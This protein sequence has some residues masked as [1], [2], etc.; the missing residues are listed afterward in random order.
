MEASNACGFVANKTSLLINRRERRER[1]EV[2]L[3][4]F[5]VFSVKRER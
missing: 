5:V 1:R 4:C 2:E 3:L